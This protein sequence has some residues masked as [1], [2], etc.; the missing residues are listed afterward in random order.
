MQSYNCRIEDLPGIFP[1]AQQQ[2]AR[3]GIA[4]AFDLLKQGQTQAQRQVLAQALNLHIKHV[5]KWV[6]LANL[7]RIPGVGVQHCG[8]LLHA[9]VSSPQQLAS[10]SVSQLHRQ[11]QR[12]Q[13]QLFSKIDDCPGPEQ[14]A[15]WIQQAKNLSLF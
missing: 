1:E 15:L 3:L 4:T 14:V 11:L 13:V 5:N 10:M 6:A 2:L 12:L 7:A 8:L 9:G